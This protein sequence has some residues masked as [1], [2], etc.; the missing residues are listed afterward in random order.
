MSLD[1]LRWLV[2]VICLNY[3]VREMSYIRRRRKRVNV[4]V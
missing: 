3:E 1:A 2:G 4:C